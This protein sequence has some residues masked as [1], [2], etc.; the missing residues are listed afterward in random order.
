MIHVEVTEMIKRPVAD[1]FAFASKPENEPL[2]D[3]GVLEARKTSEGPI[4]VNSTWHEVRQ[5][6]GR[7]IESDNVVTEYEPNKRISFRSTSGPVKVEGGYTFESV[8]GGTKVT[9]T[10]HGDPGGLFKLADPIVGRMVKRQL[11]A[12]AGNM[13]EYLEANAD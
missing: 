6:L 12:A 9:V 10:G 4:G 5:Q 3:Q 11:E 7:R 8:D 1:V 13:K 2:Y